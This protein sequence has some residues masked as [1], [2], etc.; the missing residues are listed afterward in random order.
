MN[1]IKKLGSS[2]LMMFLL[3]LTLQVIPVSFAQARP[4]SWIE[5]SETAC[6]PFESITAYRGTY[7][8]SGS[9]KTV[10]TTTYYAWG[11]IS[12]SEVKIVSC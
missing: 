3:V 2:T 8:I 7:I 10:T 1:R 5:V 4:F 12:F 9:E 11:A 6:T